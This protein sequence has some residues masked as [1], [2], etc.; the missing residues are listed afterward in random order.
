MDLIS[1]FYDSKEARLSN[2]LRAY[3]TLTFWDPRI[4]SK[5][6]APNPILITSSLALVSHPRRKS[7]YPGGHV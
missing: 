2:T 1:T 7:D 5:P 3:A 4:G 6:L